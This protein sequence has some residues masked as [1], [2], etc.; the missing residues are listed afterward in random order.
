MDNEQTPKWKTRVV[1]NGFPDRQF[2]IDF[3]QTQGDEAI[4]R[5]AWE[6]VVLAEEVKGTHR[7]LH[8]Y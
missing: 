7:H 2:D 8:A 1:K 4:F 3:W 6:M 5:A